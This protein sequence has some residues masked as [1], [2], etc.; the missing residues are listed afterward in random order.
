VSTQESGAGEDRVRVG[1][2]A[3]RPSPQRLIELVTD[4]RAGAIVTFEGV[5][6][7]VPQLQYDVDEPA[8]RE[9]IAGI[10]NDVLRRH[11][12]LGA[13][14][15]HR[16]GDAPLSEPTVAVAVSAAHRD[17]AFAGAREL[18]DRIKEDA[19]IRKREVDEGAGEW[20]AGNEPSNLED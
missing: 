8:A 5:T 7:D 2:T 3:G 12:L 16:T 1:F 4:P 15:E 9:V 13:A 10:A 18:V 20:V 14:V 19:P 11:G 6:R 17:E